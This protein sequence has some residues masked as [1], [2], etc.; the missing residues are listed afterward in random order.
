MTWEE[1]WQPGVVG[2][3]AAILGNNEVLP[4]LFQSM[5]A[6]TRALRRG[7]KREKKKLELPLELAVRVACTANVELCSYVG[8][9]AS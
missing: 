9:Y 4:M 1:D 8:R 3:E 5:Q 7:D 6:A 2:A